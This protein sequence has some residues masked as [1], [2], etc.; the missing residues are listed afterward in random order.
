MRTLP[1]CFAALMATLSTGS[2]LAADPYLLDQRDPQ[3]QSAIEHIANASQALAVARQQLIQAQRAYHLPGLD[4]QQMLDQM[5]PMEDTF[6]VLLNP[7]RKRMAHK[8][9]VPDGVFFTP[10]H[11]GD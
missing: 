5:K 3:Y 8:T 11:T 1:L 4:V 10:I 2:A 7:E 9:L 6:T